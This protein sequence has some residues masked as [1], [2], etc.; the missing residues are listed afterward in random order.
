[1]EWSG[2]CVC[3]C[4][5]VWRKHFVSFCLVFFSSGNTRGKKKRFNKVT[6]M[7]LCG[8][9]FFLESG[10]TLRMRNNNN[11]SYHREKKIAQQ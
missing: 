11:N 8:V 6:Y 9:V 4:V 2:V 5:C 1:M 3:V 7:R 10:R